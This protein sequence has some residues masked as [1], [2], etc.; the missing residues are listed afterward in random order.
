[1]TVPSINSA[2]ASRS[3]SLET[4]FNPLNQSSNG[5]SFA[6][7]LTHEVGVSTDV[8]KNFLA[9]DPSA[10]EIA[11]QAAQLGLNEDQIVQTLALGGYAGGDAASLRSKVESFVADATNG[12]AWADDGRLS[13]VRDVKSAASATV[14]KGM[15][16][17]PDIKTF[18]A[19]GPTDMQVTNKVKSLGLSA[20]QVVQF[21][22]AGM[23]LNVN[24]INA[25][26]LETM[27]VDAAN[28][29]GT[30]IGGGAHG[31]WTSYFSPTLGRAVTKAE[32]QDFFSGKPDQAQIFQKAS[33]LG[34]GIGAVNNMMN[35]L[36][37]TDADAG[38]GSRFN[39][40]ATSLY[41]GR[42]GYSLDQQGHIVAGGGNQFASN[43]DGSGTW[44]PKQAS[45]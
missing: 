10:R 20:A 12:Y 16:S 33:Q 31:A 35:G 3:V 40:M 32:M 28:R 19:T 11:D 18:Y 34:L 39:Q 45:A 30:S 1:M 22:A 26:V 17:L 14:G 36:G 38:Y 7:A 21:E 15:P 6:A 24:Q 4:R 41:Q 29:L 44:I 9:S 25:N 23:G 37:L 2:P 27:Y 43:A 8:V 5:E 13:A 42:N